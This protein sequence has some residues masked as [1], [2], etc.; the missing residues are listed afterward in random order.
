MSSPTAH[1]EHDFSKASSANNNRPIGTGATGYTFTERV[2][3]VV[4]NIAQK[5]ALYSSRVGVS[6]YFT[7][8]DVLTEL[9]S[10]GIQLQ[11]KTAYLG[12]SH[13]TSGDRPKLRRVG[14]YFI[15]ATLTP[16]LFARRV[17]T[18]LPITCAPLLVLCQTKHPLHVLDIAEAT[19]LATG[20]HWGRNKTASTLS[21]QS[22]LREV[23]SDRR[24]PGLWTWG[25]K[26]PSPVDI[27]ATV[28]QFV[29]TD[30]ETPN[31]RV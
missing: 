8:A 23:N 4:D 22:R 10:L 11:A 27:D 16:E 24:N 25:K 21:T 14:H 15:R 19:T 30:E 13:M 6:P 26:L 12:L 7:V 18:T 28:C 9:S 20:E 31:D 2:E 29:P 1:L 3:E 5:R 17:D